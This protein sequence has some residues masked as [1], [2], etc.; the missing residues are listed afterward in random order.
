[1]PPARKLVRSPGISA[2]ETG[3]SAARGRISRQVQL[4]G[5]LGLSAFCAGCF[6]SAAVLARSGG[7]A[8]ATAPAQTFDPLH[9]NPPRL[10]PAPKDEPVDAVNA[11]AV[12]DAFQKAVLKRRVGQPGQP[13]KAPLIQQFTNQAR[14]LL[15]AEL[16]FAR[17]VCHLN[18]E[19]LRKLND[20]AQKML[21]EVVTKLVDAQFEPRVRVQMGGQ[22][23]G[24]TVGNLDAHQLLEEGV[25]AVL[26]RDLSPKQWSIYEAEREKRDENRKRMTIRYF[27]DAIDR[28]LYL[29]TT[30][31]AQLKHQFESHWEPNWSLYLENHLYGNRYYPMTIDSLVIPILS[32][33][34]QIV[35]HGVQK[36]GVYWGFAGMLGGFA[37]DGDALEVELGGPAR[38]ERNVNGMIGGLQ[39]EMQIPRA[40]EPRPSS[41]GTRAA[42]A[43]PAPTD[44]QKKA[45]KSKRLSE[46]LEMISTER[47]IRTLLWMLTVSVIACSGNAA[48]GQDEEIIDDRPIAPEANL[49][50]RMVR[51]VQFTPEQVDQWVF[52]RWGGLAATRDRLEADLALRIDDLDRACAITPVQQKKLKL[53]GMGDIKRYFDRVDQLKQRFAGESA[54]ARGNVNNIWQEM[55][56]LQIELNAGL[57]GTNSF[58]VKTLKS[59]LDADQAKRYEELLQ[60]RAAE[61]GS[62]TIEWFVVHIDKALGLSELQRRRLVELLAKETPPPQRFGQA[63]FWY[64]MYQLTRVPEDRIRAILDEPQWRLLNRQFAQ[65]R[66][67]EPWLKSNGLI[68]PGTQPVAAIHAIRLRNVAAPAPDPPKTLDEMKK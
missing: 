16:I 59:T 68:A 58:F 36:V 42:A 11:K 4:L 9:P 65:A 13:N 3:G 30:Q 38:A 21:D 61:R 23:Q 12:G 22:P 48:F 1:M 34:Q 32:N 31:R 66:G 47:R 62:A 43:K 28:E 2:C 57:F 17:H 53:A 60:E 55:Q 10:K 46:Y 33:A 6:A 7:A 8:Q 37:N 63:D 64:L 15:R 40:S 18:R 27:V 45:E 25:V 26:K 54:S 51:A 39:M 49:P 35:W 67:M 19:E 29:S 41:F 20:D 44:L 5:T 50:A 52:N 56:P 24:R 14:P